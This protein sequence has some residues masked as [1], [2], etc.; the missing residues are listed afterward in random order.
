MRYRGIKGR[1]WNAVKAYVRSKEKDCYT[2]GAKNLQ[3]QNYQAGHFIPVALAG[4]NNRLSW[5]ALQIHA[6]C[7]RCNGMGQGE[8]V[9]Y[10]DHLV[11]DYGTK[12]VKE[13]EARRWKVDKITNWQ[14]VIDSYKSINTLRK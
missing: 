10:R 2:C 4:S 8:Q 5:D 9:A 12:V 11:R 13:L 14:E 1:A 7:G 6:Q 3:G